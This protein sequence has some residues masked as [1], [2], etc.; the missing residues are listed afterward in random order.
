MLTLR[1]VKCNIIIIFLCD[2]VATVMKRTKKK[3]ATALNDLVSG[4]TRNEHLANN[5]Q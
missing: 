5:C 1:E 4:N 3:V 2:I